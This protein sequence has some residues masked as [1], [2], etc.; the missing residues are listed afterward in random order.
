MDTPDDLIK[1]LT[2]DLKPVT[3]LAPDWQRAVIFASIGLTLTFGTAVLL[4]LRDDLVAHLQRMEFLAEIAAMLL[5]GFLSAGAAVKLAVPDTR[6][7]LPV[8][9]PLALAHLAWFW[10][11][12]KTAFNLPI[13]DDSGHG[14]CAIDLTLMMILPLAAATGGI[15][16]GAPV[17][18]GLAGYAM[19][20]SMVSFAAA[21]MR[22]LCPNDE[23]GHL[24]FWHFLPAVG[25]AVLGIVIGL[26]AFRQK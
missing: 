23:A 12:A 24:L 18:R 15:M 5:A 17:F 14:A 1:N 22:L 16:R 4:G 8:K 7:R 25:I 10:L 21:A 9:L 6:L 20:L 19:S 11:L 2:R 3:P 13:S 26:F